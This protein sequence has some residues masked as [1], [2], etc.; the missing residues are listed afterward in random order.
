M[1]PQEQYEALACLE[2]I[3]AFGTARHCKT[4]IDY[5]VIPSLLD[6]ATLMGEPFFL[7]VTFRTLTNICITVKDLSITAE[8]LNSLA[9][10]NLSKKYSSEYCEFMLFKCSVLSKLCRNEADNF[11]KEIFDEVIYLVHNALKNISEIL[12]NKTKSR[13]SGP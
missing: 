2:A 7:T 6:V 1:R 8:V 3:V 12:K 5:R 11:S 9:Q 13:L 4:I 10:V